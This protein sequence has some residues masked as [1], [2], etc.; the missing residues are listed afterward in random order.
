MQ[1]KEEPPHQN[2]QGS[3]LLADHI[4]DFVEKG[5]LIHK[6]TFDEGQ[7]KRA[8]YDVRLGKA[9]YKAGKYGNLSDDNPLLEI[10]PYELVFVESYEIFEMPKNVVAMYDLRVSGCLGGMG[11]QT[12]LQIDPTY[13]GR[14]FCPLFNF[15]DTRVTLKYKHHLASVQFIYTTPSTPEA[16]AYAPLDKTRQGLLSLSDVLTDVLRQSGLQ[17]LWTE[18]NKA[19]ADLQSDLDKYRGEAT[20]LH[21]RVDIMV[22]AVFQAMAFLIAALGVMGAAMSISITSKFLVAPFPLLIGLIILF[23]IAFGALGFLRNRRR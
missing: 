23:V 21:E 3:V 12:G 4:K 2:Y 17:R 13:C 14:I 10:E 5:W 16:E 1:N 6:D 20:R 7:L 8:K 19:Q 22:G 18:V 9:Y 11:L 15:S